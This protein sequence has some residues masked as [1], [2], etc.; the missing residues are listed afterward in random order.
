MNNLKDEIEFEQIANNKE[1]ILKVNQLI[2][3]NK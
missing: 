2:V 1:V 3:N